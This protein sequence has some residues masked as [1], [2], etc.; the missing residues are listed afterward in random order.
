MV[1]DLLFVIFIVSLRNADVSQ[2]C[3]PDLQLMQIERHRNHDKG[4]KMCD[5]LNSCPC[6]RKLECKETERVDEFYRQM[7]E[8]LLANAPV[9]FLTG[10]RCPANPVDCIKLREYK[11]RQLQKQR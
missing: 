10:G 5:Y 4:I 3:V 1:K 7:S 2:N 8:A 11:I 6:E 9:Y